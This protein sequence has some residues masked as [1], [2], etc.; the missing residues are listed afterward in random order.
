[1]GKTQN[2]IVI[3]EITP[4]DL[5][6]YFEMLVELRSLSPTLYQ[7]ACQTIKDK[8]TMAKYVCLN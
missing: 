1:M 2:G 7:E 3:L 4:V 8:H 6:P 5:E